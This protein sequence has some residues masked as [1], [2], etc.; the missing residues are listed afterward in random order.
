MSSK[1]CPGFGSL[2]SSLTIH[3]AGNGDADPRCWGLTT[4]SLYI[5]EIALWR[6]V[7]GKQL[8]ILK[9]ERSWQVCV[10]NSLRALHTVKSVHSQA[11]NNDAFEK[12]VA[13]I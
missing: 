5:H 11:G 4:P 9:T 2:P 7:A 10:W 3:L 12:R 13:E 6:N 1:P 8:P